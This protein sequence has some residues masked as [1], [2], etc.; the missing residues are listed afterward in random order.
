MTLSLIVGLFLTNVTALFAEEAEDPCWTLYQT[1]KKFQQA[2]NYEKALQLYQQGLS[3]QCQKDLKFVSTALYESGKIYE[4]QQR[5]D[6]AEQAFSK[7]LTISEEIYGKEDK[8]VAFILNRLGIIYQ[9]K[10]NYDKA[11]PLYRKS[12]DI[13]KKVLGK[14]H[15]SIA[16]SLNNLALLYKTTGNYDKALSFYEQ[17]LTICK[18][19]LG[20]EHFNVAINLGNLANLYREM[21]DY[22]KALPLLQ[23]SLAIL[24][25]VFGEEH[26]HIATALN[27]LALLHYKMS[28]YDK[29]LSLYQKSLT[30]SK[31]VL[32]EEHIDIATRFNNL[33]TLYQMRG[34]YASALSLYEQAL[35]IRKKI[36]GESHIDVAQSLSNLANLYDEMGNNDKALR[37]SQQSLAIYKKVL[38]AESPNVATSFNNLAELYRKMGNYEKALPLYQKALNIREKTLGKEHPHIAQSFSNLALLYDNMGNYDKALLLYEKSLSIYKKVLGEEH[39][40][41]AINLNNLV[42]LYFKLKNHEKAELLLKEVLPI[43]TNSGRPEILWK[44]QSA[45]QYLLVKQNNFDAAIFFGK[46]AVNTIQSL[47]ANISTMDKS[48]QK[49]FLG[50]KKFVYQSLADLLI[51]QGRIPEAQQVLDM[52]KEEEYFDFIRRSAEDD[53]RSTRAN[54]STFEQPWV[55]RY[56]KITQ[57]LGNLGEERRKL[58]RKAKLKIISDIEKARL[59]EL[60]EI[61]QIEFKKFTAFIEEVK[62]AFKQA[63]IVDSEK[64]IKNLKNLQNMLKTLG[65]GVVLIHYLITEDKLRL[66]LTTADFQVVRDAAV[67]RKDL[68]RKI[69]QFKKNIK[70]TNVWDYIKDAKA[71]YQWIIK[72]IESDLEK[73]KATMLMLSLDGV[74]RYIPIAAL[75]DENNKYLMQRYATALYTSAGQTKL[76]HKPQEKWTVA[77][78]GLS[79]AVSG[80][81]P[82]PSVID[83]LNN[84]IKQDDSDETGVMQGIVY[85]NKKFNA[86]AM[87]KVLNEKYPV[88][89][90][91]SHFVF[92][93]GTLQNSYLLLG[94]GEH[95]NLQVIKESYNFNNLDL[96]TLSACNTATGANANGQEIEGFGALAQNKGA[97][98]VLATLWSVDDSSTGEFMQRLYELRTSEPELSKAEAIQQIQQSFLKEGGWRKAYYWAPFILMGNWL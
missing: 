96:L 16:Q 60:K 83:E 37:L 47:R 2:K 58:A 50:N 15:P 84:I 69:F 52:L 19:V 87:L 80:F 35:S 48:L 95:L 12:L 81:N 17:S 73:A 10:G 27:N 32:G 53:N 46:Q 4:I 34:N 86:D 21:G 77:G 90:I 89:H 5:F 44:T 51:D 78:L 30:I 38:G 29:A 75:I 49:S 11:L 9:K 76:T 57:H 82:L 67:T 56:Q 22:D 55:E 45:L 98:G 6:E 28:N 91:A 3:K 40:D 31:K 41:I 62:I 26:P 66:I 14:E 43:A 79:D 42:V 59:A 7:S 13:K 65:E 85:L 33:A 64:V 63:T 20:E 92:Q 68:N 94:T 72:P 61:I 71:L 25:K 8:I 23:K 74:L 97:K 36:L 70:I 39:P 93:P 24:R 54:F 18:E 88:L 1:A